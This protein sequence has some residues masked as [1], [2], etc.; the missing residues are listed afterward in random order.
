MVEVRDFM[1]EGPAGK[2]ATRAKGLEDNPGRIVVLVQGA[3][4]KGS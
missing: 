3:N 4:L 1:I 2:L